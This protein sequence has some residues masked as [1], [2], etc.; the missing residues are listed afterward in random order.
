MTAS[1]DEEDDEE[2]ETEDSDSD[3]ADADVEMT[4]ELKAEEGDSDLK[5]LF[6]DAN[7]QSQVSSNSVLTSLIRL[8]YHFLLSVSY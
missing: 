8:V 2:A 3:D 7:K 5:T 4:D 1:P 6:E